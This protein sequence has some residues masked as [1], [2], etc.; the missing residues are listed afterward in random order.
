MGACVSSQEGVSEEDKARNRE[1]ERQLKEAKIKLDNQ[2][3]V[4]ISPSQSSLFEDADASYC[5]VGLAAG[6]RRLRKIYYSQS[7]SHNSL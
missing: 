5:I 3:K 2:V 1:V 7:E 6:L 4:S